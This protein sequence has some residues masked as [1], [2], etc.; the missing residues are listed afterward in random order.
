MSA[1]EAGA[2]SLYARDM[3]RRGA[4]AVLVVG[5]AALSACG[6][7]PPPV[8]GV[9]LSS[10]FVSLEHRSSMG[11]SFVLI[12]ASATLDG[13]PFGAVAVDVSPEGEAQGLGVPLCLGRRTVATG[14][15]HL[16][17]EL[18]YAGHGYGVF[19]YL[20]DYRFRAQGELDV[21][22]PEDASGVA[23]ISTGYENGGAATPI[24]DRPSI[25]WHVDVVRF[26][27]ARGCEP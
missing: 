10:G 8:R 1:R 5:L 24:E 13:E 15:H 9:S 14:M 18:T 27:A 12:G 21:E 19:S 11:S 25:S 7:A 17:L 23:V 16:T 22:L 20:R 6:A 4:I 3:L 26:E 2:A